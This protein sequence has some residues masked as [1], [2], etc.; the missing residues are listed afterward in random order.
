MQIAAQI[1]GWALLILGLPLFWTPIP[2]GA[3]MI[4]VG[5]A[6]IVSSSPRARAW[7]RLRRER[8]PKLDE[9]LGRAEVKTP[10]RFAET[11]EKTDGPEARRLHGK[12]SRDG[13]LNASR[14]G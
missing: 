12:R 5:A 9:A 2:V 1:A 6:L 13:A 3:A 4:A 10:E 8:H 7:L 11:L 14:R